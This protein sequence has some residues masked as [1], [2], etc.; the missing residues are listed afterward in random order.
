MGFVE[1]VARFV[2][3]CY[4]LYPDLRSTPLEPY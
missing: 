4:K 3:L 1:R 2:D